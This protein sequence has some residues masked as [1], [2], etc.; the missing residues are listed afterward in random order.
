VLGHDDRVGIVER[1]REHVP[2]VLDGRGGDDAQPGHV[3]EPVLEGVGV[4]G[5]EL[6]PAAGA[7]HDRD[8]EVSARHMQQGSGVVE[9]LVE[10]Q[11]AEVAGHDLDDREH[12]GQ[13]GPDAGPGVGRFAKGSAEDPWFAEF[14]QQAFAHGETA[15]VAAHVGSHQKDPGVSFKGGAQGLAQG[16]AVGQRAGFAGRRLW[17]GQRIAGGWR[18]LFGIDE[19]LQVGDRLPGASFGEGNPFCDFRLDLLFEIGEV[20]CGDQAVGV[21]LGAEAGDRV[22]LAPRSAPLV[23]LGRVRRRTSSGRESGRRGT[24]AAGGRRQL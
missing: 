7:D 19:P 14:I 6:A 24:R 17:F 11:Q 10:G 18:L 12:A 5:G 23:C 2:G 21:Q 3:G 13:G 9:D 16:L 22:L 4:L 15:A 1:G 8:G 20:L